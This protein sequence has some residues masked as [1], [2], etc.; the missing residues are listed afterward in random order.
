MKAIVLCAGYGTRL[1]D[2]TRDTPKPMLPV[3]NH[4]LLAYLLGHL[5]THAFSEIAIN[6]HF[7][8]EIIR[9]AFGDGSRW[10]LR[11]HYSHE[12][13]LLGT[14]GA[15][16]HLESYFRNEP[17]FLIQYGDILTDHD[18]SALVRHHLQ[19]NALATLLVHPRPHSNSA[20]T[21]DPEGRIV[22][23]VERP[24]D[25]LR[26]GIDTPWVNSGL[27]IAS[28][29]L[30]NH[31]PADRP[32]DLPRDVFVPLVHSRRLF[33]MP[34]HGFRCAIDSPERLALA[35]TAIAEHHCDI[36]PLDVPCQETAR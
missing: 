23:F 6:L 33:A 21:L 10:N 36:H 3:G 30:L 24:T 27:C 4:P 12:P 15:V 13:V 35:R 26:A 14:A 20:V 22:G 34:L 16:K 7:R 18:V 28:P 32:A 9:D 25:P 17:F 31:I 29:E 8:P 11:L 19:H 1:G 2:L 5:R